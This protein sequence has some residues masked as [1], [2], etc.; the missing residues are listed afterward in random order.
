MS[1]AP[2]R[3]G[4]RTMREKLERN[5]ASMKLQSLTGTNPMIEK[6]QAMIEALPPKR[7][8]VKRP[9]DGKRADD[10]EANVIDAVGDLLHVHPK[11]LFAARQNSGSLPFTNN[12]GKS[13]PIWF[14]KLVR[15]PEKLTIV[16]Y[17]GFL[18]DKRPFAF[19]C[20]KPSWKPATPAN[21]R[22]YAHELEQ[23]VFLHMI[24]SL[25]GVSGFVT[26]ASQVV[27]MLE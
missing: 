1:Y 17:W 15:K 25:G 22:D 6:M 10:L 4:R 12:K 2:I 7:H 20:K 11:V 18:A 14:Y 26:D 24:R 8:R 9:V 16:D 5:L 3:R 27:E 21:R 19:E 13:Y 23:Q